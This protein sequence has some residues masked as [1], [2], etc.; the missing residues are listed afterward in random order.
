MTIDAALLNM[1][2]FTQSV[3][4]GPSADG[5][6]MIAWY[7]AA[8]GAQ[9]AAAFATSPGYSLAAVPSPLSNARDFLYRFITGTPVGW[10]KRAV[11]VQSWY[12]FNAALGVYENSVRDYMGSGSQWVGPFPQTI[13]TQWRNVLSTYLAAWMTAKALGAELL[14]SQGSPPAYVPPTA[15]V[16]PMVNPKVA[17]SN[18]PPNPIT[19]F[20]PTAQAQIMGTQVTSISPNAAQGA[21]QGMGPA[22]YS[23]MQ[24][25][26]AASVATDAGAPL[27]VPGT[28]A[29]G[30]LDQFRPVNE[31]AVHTPLYKMPAFWVA[32]GGGLLLV[33]LAGGLLQKRRRAA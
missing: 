25:Q 14:Q 30:S 8:N 6:Y 1:A 26:Q 18:A 22:E 17:S 15:T 31:L 24:A 32:I 10:S 12:A 11:A 19:Q 29:G 28:P 5:Q 7:S 33:G 21:P 2:G 4:P 27:E 16:S 20:S 13:A 3:N 23:R 9:R